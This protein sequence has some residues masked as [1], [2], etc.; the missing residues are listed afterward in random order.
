MGRSGLLGAN[1]VQCA[2]AI[3]IRL[4]PGGFE[5]GYSYFGGSMHFEPLCIVQVPG[6][7]VIAGDPDDLDITIGERSWHFGIRQPSRERFVVFQQAFVAGQAVRRLDFARLN[8]H[9]TGIERD[10]VRLEWNPDTVICANDF[11][12]LEGLAPALT[13]AWRYMNKGVV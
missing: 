9:L 2:E 10:R 12:H 6:M 11:L 4:K 7:T 8:V 5:V 3:E 1:C 13:Q